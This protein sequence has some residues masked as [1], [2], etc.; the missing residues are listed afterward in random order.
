MKNWNKMNWGLRVMIGLS[1][2]LSPLSFSSVAAQSWASKAAKSVFTLKTF[3]ADGT[4]IGSANGFFVSEDGDAVSIY[5]PFAGAVRAVVIDASG[6][7]MPVECMIGANEMYDVAKFRVDGKKMQP[8]TIASSNAQT[9]QQV[10]MLPYSVKKSTPV[11]GQM[12]K[13]ETFQESYAY[14]TVKMEIPENTVGCPL[15]NEN[16]EVIGLMQQSASANQSAA[17]PQQLAYAI[18]ARYANDMKISGLSMNDAS[19]QKTGIKIAMPD[20]K[21]D[22]MLMMY[23]AG[24]TRD[25]LSYAR[26]VD[27][28]IAK[29][30]KAE[31]GY[32]NRAQLAL[33][34]NDL[35]AAARD[36]QQAISASNPKDN[37]HYAYSRMIYAYCLQHEESGHQDWTFDKAAE[38]AKAAYDISPLSAYKHQLGQVLFAQKKY[39]EA[40]AIF[41]ELAT[42]DIQGAEIYYEA[43]R[44]HEMKGDTTQM[45]ALLDSAVNVFSK[46]YLKEAAPYIWARGLARMN[47]GKHRLA[48]QDMNEYE[49]LIPTGL[50]A[51]FYYIRE[52]AEI[53]GR[54]FQQALNDITKA[55]Q[56]EPDDPDYFGEKASLE[57]RVG[58]YDEAAASARECIRLAPTNSDGYLLLGVALCQKGDKKNGL[59][60]L[61]KAKEL[62]SKQADALMERYK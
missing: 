26:I 48:V 54:Q 15:L 18:S 36:M 30:P 53:G 56:L 24:S 27:D 47:A 39:D 6:K 59:L 31:E 5:A 29:F 46:P 44:C 55:T 37:A 62:G 9:G 3:G 51:R 17:T 40:L 11:S 60:Q 28:F 33:N 34:G 7:E 35:A 41:N 2:F 13:A 43:A 16:G 50:N 23:L 38:E 20:N 19:L 57:N 32:I 49:K 45:L 61:Q 52:Q 22:A 1:L 25:S 8:L 58:L 10:W 42:S 4:L 14:Y 12:D 21:D